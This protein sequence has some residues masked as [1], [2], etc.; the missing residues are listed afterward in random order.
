MQG[1]VH[2]NNSW[3][4]HLN[5]LCNSIESMKH[6]IRTKT[7]PECISSRGICEL[8]EIRESSTYVSHKVIFL[9]FVIKK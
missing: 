5:L 6:F 4:L 8:P 9:K 1:I 3:L 2:R 7:N